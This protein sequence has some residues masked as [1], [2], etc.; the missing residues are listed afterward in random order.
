MYIILHYI[1]LHCIA[2]HCIA[3]QYITSHKM[4]IHMTYCNELRLDEENMRIGSPGELLL[5]WRTILIA[6]HIRHNQMLHLAQWDYFKDD[7]TI[8]P[9]NQQGEKGNHGR[10]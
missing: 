9:C 5:Q 8:E 6:I 3:L 1:T 10:S 2:L 4:D 7:F